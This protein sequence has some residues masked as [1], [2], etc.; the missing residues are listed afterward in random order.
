MLAFFHIVV[1]LLGI[2]SNEKL[3]SCQDVC[4]WIRSLSKD[5]VPYAEIFKEHN[6]DAYWL[7]NHINDENLKEYGIERA[8]HRHAILDNIEQLKKQ[9]SVQIV[10]ESK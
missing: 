8:D 2:Y 4:K 1:F 6:V 5:Y 7:L 9:C 3:N 10:P